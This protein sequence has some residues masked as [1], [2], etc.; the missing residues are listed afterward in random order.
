M[1]NLLAA[2]A[3]MGVSFVFHIIYATLGIGLPLLLM[4]AEERGEHTGTRAT[5]CREGA[6]NRI[7]CENF[8]FVLCWFGRYARFYDQRSAR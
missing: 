2:R 7:G 8:N 1:D 4:L 6:L 3:L 5:S